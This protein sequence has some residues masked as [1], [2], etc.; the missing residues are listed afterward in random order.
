MD[1]FAGIVL[2]ALAARLWQWNEHLNL[3]CGLV[4]AVSLVR[5]GLLEW[6]VHLANYHSVISVR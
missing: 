5:G 2:L 4:S 1:L 3:A 6:I